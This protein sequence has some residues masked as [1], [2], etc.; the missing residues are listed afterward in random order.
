MGAQVVHKQRHFVVTGLH[1]QLSQPFYEALR[2]DWE[3]VDLEVL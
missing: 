1:S 2:I 3:I